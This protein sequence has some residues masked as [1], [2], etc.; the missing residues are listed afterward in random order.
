MLSSLVFN[1]SLNDSIILNLSVRPL[2][3]AYRQGFKL[4]SP[5]M[6]RMCI[7]GP[8]RMLSKMGLIDHD[9]QGHF[10]LK[11]VDCLKF[12]LV[13]TIVQACFE[14]ESP[15]LHIMCIWNLL[16]P[17]W[18]W[19]RLTLNF[20]VIFVKCVNAI[21]QEWINRSI[22]DENHLDRGVT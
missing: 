10:G 22:S 3:Y 18:K 8:F 11:R 2:V 14:L 12:E 21:C 5:F 4:K 20:E 7:L 9:F 6:N 1:L 17:H 19:S 16:E 15:F 13:C